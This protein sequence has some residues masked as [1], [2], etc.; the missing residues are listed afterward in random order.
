V[1]GRLDVLDEVVARGVLPRRLV[2]ADALDGS[3]L[4]SL[5]VGEEL[6]ARYGGPYVVVHRSDLLEVLVGACAAAGVALE[7]GRQTVDVRQDDDSAVVVCADG[8]VHR[9]G[10]VVGADGLRSAL[11]ARLS[12]DGPVSSGYVAYRGTGP[13]E[14]ASERVDPSC[15]GRWTLPSTDPGTSTGSTGPHRPDPT[16]P[17][18]RRHPRC[19]PGPA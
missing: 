11:R 10:A 18:S 1:L 7:N 15:C 16:G 13:F 17:P 8:S 3:E 12:D 6:R 14:Q 4:T 19:A 2:L 9:A 5:A